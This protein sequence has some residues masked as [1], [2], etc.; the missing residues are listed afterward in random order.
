V[1]RTT[2]RRAL[3]PVVLVTLIFTFLLP[4]FFGRSFWLRDM[5]VFHYP[6]KAYLRSRLAV[7]ELALWNPYLGLGRPFLG[8]IQPGVLYPLNIIL[9]LP[10]PRGID[11]FFALHAPL[12]ALGMRAWLRAHG[13]ANGDGEIAAA[14][15]GALLALSGYYVSQLAGNGSYA[16]GVAWVPWAAWAQA[17]FASD[18]NWRRAVPLVALFLALMVLAG[19]P[20]AVGFALALLVCEALAAERV[21]RGRAFIVVAGGALG[22]LLLAAVQL[23]PALEVAAVG[24]PGGVPLVE[25]QHFSFP[26][27]R[28]IELVWPGAFGTP[29]S[30]DWLLHGLYDEGSGL[31]YEPW[32]AG[33]YV[34]L[35]TPLFAVAAVAR[36]RRSRRDIALFLLLSGS[37][38]IAFGWHTPLFAVFF[39]H[40]PGAHQFRYPEKYLFVTTLAA[41]ALAAR[42]IEAAVEQPARA[43]VLGAALVAALVGGWL[44]AAG[45][46]G[47]WLVHAVGR[48]GAI[49][50]AVAG[51]TLTARARLA[52]AV[53]TAMLLPLGLAARGRLAPRGLRA[54]LTAIVVID[55]VA[56]S[57][58]LVDYVPADL[59]RETPPP[60]AL[61]RARGALGLLRLYRPR[62]ADYSVAGADAAAILRGTL[63][64]DCGVEA[65]VAQLDAYENFPLPTEQLLWRALAQQPLRL[66]EILGARIVLTGTSLWRPQ[67]GLELV[68]AWPEL[69]LVLA[70][71][72]H[73]A[74]RVYLARDTRAAD[75]ATA[76][77]LL[78][79]ADFVPGASAVIAAD[80]DVPATRADGR[81]SLVEDRPERLVLDCTSDAPSYAIVGDAFFPGWR[82]TVD[83]RPA[84]IHRANLAL[85]AVPVAA[86]RHSIT[87]TYHPAHLVSGAVVS[88]LACLTLLALFG[89]SRRYNTSVSTTLASDAR[90]LTVSTRSQ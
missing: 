50:P 28:L 11:L 7:G 79:A 84:P 49:T 59:Y 35:A 24:R 38:L 37:L 73:P 77:A 51:A 55:L 75:D 71:V 8:V 62:Y 63:R 2:M 66:L 72:T 3:G 46:G 1:I 14:F 23:G 47:R 6:L 13:P 41:C 53:A 33:I 83:G 67:P 60:L 40:V 52:V 45:P 44:I 4:I 42:G 31:D 58:P 26:P 69:H 9:L 61:A 21:R 64:P 76:A 54:A 18:G 88:A 89:W 12:A 74:P 32:S 15:A 5:V 16:V 10:F 81:C 30:P 78:A 29:Y 87:L 65:G 43:L 17:R 85:R 56:A 34:G 82:A 57:T 80:G 36:R 68:R 19:D 22:A 70:E 20:Q 39:N 48:A 25:A 86:G 90:L 27:L